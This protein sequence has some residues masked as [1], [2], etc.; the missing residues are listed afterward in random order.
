MTKKKVFRTFYTATYGYAYG[1]H[2]AVKIETVTP[3]P[4]FEDKNSIKVLTFDSRNFSGIQFDE[5]SQ[6]ELEK[7]IESRDLKEAGGPGYVDERFN[8]LVWKTDEPGTFEFR[9]SSFIEKFVEC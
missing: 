7:R 2:G 6:K 4:P 1:N 3:N 9:K 5:I 8:E